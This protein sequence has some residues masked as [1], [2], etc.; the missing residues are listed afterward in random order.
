MYL[1]SKKG[2]YFPN[3]KRIIKNLYR[4]TLILHSTLVNQ[5]PEY[6]KLFYFLTTIGTYSLFPLLFRNEGKYVI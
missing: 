2:K 4:F 6:A 1:R 3:G 5:S